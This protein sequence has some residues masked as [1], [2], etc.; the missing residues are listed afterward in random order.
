MF[1][2]SDDDHMSSGDAF[3]GK[4]VLVTGA[5]GFLG[6]HLVDALVNCGADVLGVD[7][8]AESMSPKT[9]V[10]TRAF[11]LGD[12]IETLQTF[13]EFRPEYVYHLAAPPD[14]QEDFQQVR[15]S[16][17]GSICVT[18]NLLEAFR[19]YPGDLFVYGDS[20]KVYG[21][22]GVAYDETLREDPLSSY[23]ICKSS[24]W[25]FCKYHR[26]L[27][28]TNVVSMRPTIVYGPGQP[29]NVIAYVIDEILRGHTVIKL[30]GGKQTRDPL[31]CADLMRAY[32]AVP[33][34]CDRI[35]GRVFSLGGGQEIAIDALVRKIAKL[36][37]AEIEIETDPSQIRPTDSMRSFCLNTDAKR[38]LGWSPQIDLDTGLRELIAS[39]TELLAVERLLS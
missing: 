16:I 4:R 25:Q 14:A 24:A 9:M 20:S 26:R 12:P 17:S 38:W 29:S 10:A 37:Q 11:D 31:H 19:Q 23:A 1:S 33:G 22:P 39:R 27:Y 15:K 34:R 21:D 18:V 13:D 36:M 6:S 5:G 3:N 32:L 30:M 2:L 7:R 35:S 8:S 28:G